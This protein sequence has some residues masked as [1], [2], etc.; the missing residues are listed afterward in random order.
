MCTGKANRQ[1]Q[2]SA[3]R[4][5]SFGNA[6]WTVSHDAGKRIRPWDGTIKAIVMVTIEYLTRPICSGERNVFGIVT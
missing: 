6:A 3:G 4:L 2:N 5:D 1:V